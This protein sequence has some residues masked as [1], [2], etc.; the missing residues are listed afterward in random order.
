MQT[1]IFLF[2]RLPMQTHVFLLFLSAVKLHDFL[3]EGIA[4]VRILIDFH[5]EM[6]EEFSLSS[7]VF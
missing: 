4:G 7:K 6:L 3:R 5:S 2:M 1:Y